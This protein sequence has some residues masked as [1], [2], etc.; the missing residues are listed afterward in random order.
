MNHPLFP[1]SVKGLK[2]TKK[3]K[4]LLVAANLCKVVVHLHPETSTL[5]LMDDVCTAAGAILG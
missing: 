5:S 2:Q 3:V 4:H 1:E